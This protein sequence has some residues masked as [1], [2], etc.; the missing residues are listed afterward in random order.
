MV[1]G[2]DEHAGRGLR[3]GLPDCAAMRMKNETRYPTKMLRSMLC[4][5]HRI[6]AKHEGRLKTWASL[7]VI[8]SHSTARCKRGCENQGWG[9]Y[10]GSLVWLFLQPGETLTA[11]VYALMEHELLHSYGYRH[12]PGLPCGRIRTASAWEDAAE[13]RG[14][15]F[16]A[17]VG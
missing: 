7:L 14:V 2:L 6:L 11:G 12:G 1:V 9:R 5:V 4:E 3:L 16:E 17:R 8:I 10:D 13:K 15:L